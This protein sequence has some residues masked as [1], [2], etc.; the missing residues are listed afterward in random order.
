MTFSKQKLILAVSVALAGSIKPSI[1][2][3]DQ[4]GIS[5]LFTSADGSIQFIE[6]STLVANQQDLSGQLLVATNADNQQSSSLVFPNNLS[7]ETANTTVLIA[8]DG[9][10]QLT[11]LTPDFVIAAGFLP[12]AGGNLNFAE[13]AATV[14]YAAAQMP[15]NGLQSING[16]G[17]P[18][19]ASPRSFAGLLASIQAP[20]RASIDPENLIMNVPVLDAPGIGI[21]NVSFQVD[22]GT[23]GFT[24]LD[25]FFLYGPGI[26]AGEG[27]AEFQNDSVLV[28]PALSFST[29][30]Y[31]LNLSL[32]SGDPIVFGNPEVI[33]VTNLVPTPEPEPTPL[34]LSIARGQANYASL[35]ASCHAGDGSGGSGPGLKFTSLNFSQMSSIVNAGM[36][37]N[38]SSACRDMGTATCA[39]DVTNFIL[40]VFEQ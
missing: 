31:H 20:V 27:A 19:I 30:V 14:D 10:E 29:D 26:I 7:G 24:L 16:L 35:C 4:W 22:L 1:A 18:Q 2:D 36:P 11:G 25:N 39:T 9:F 33:S 37:R 23:L 5:E 15:R 40:N 17:E 38:N 21:A 32:L 8:T 34:E 28:L 12:L 6:L 3:F 13:G